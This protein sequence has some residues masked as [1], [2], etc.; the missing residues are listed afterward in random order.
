MNHLSEENV[1]Q[2]GDGQIGR[3]KIGPMEE[4]DGGI[5]ETLLP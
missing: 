4:R 5:V 3:P 1:S 2:K